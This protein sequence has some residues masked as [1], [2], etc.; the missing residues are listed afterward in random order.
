MKRL[1]VSLLSL[2]AFCAPALAQAPYPWNL[3]TV[4]INSTISVTS[5][6]QS[7]LAVQSG[8][9]HGCLIQNTGTHTE[10]VYFGAIASATTSNAFQISPGQT[11]SCASVYGV[12]AQDAVNITGTAGD[13]Y[14]VT[15]Q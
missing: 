15:S 9:R 5:T 14:V 2:L 8:G 1:T 12:I 10:Y 3:N 7:A 6:F 11:I 4:T 13:G